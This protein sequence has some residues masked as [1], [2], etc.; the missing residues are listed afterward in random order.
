MMRSI[1]RWTSSAGGA[2]DG[3]DGSDTAAAAGA[4]DTAAAAGTP[5]TAAASGAPDT[6]AAAGAPGTAAAVGATDNSAGAPDAAAALASVERSTAAA[7]NPRPA[8]AGTSRRRSAAST[9]GIGPGVETAGPPRTRASLP[10]PA[11]SGPLRSWVSTLASIDRPTRSG[12]VRICFGIERDREPARRWTI[13]IQL[14]VAFCAGRMANA[15]PVPAES[16][17]IAAAGSRRACRRRRPPTRPAGRCACRR[18]WLSLKLAS[19]QTWS[20]GDHRHQRRAGGDPLADLDRLRGR[21]TRRPGRR[22]STGRRPASPRERGPR[23]AARS[24]GSRPWSRRS[25]PGW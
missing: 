1:S 17:A 7:A 14:P 10:L 6:A 9:A 11:T 8:A 22:S 23:R 18:S 12:C 21:R 3:D 15:A 4:P 25:A 16:P 5:D 19:T 24:D 2:V 13:L 20:S